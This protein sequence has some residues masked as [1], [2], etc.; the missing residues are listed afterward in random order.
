MK[1]ISFEVVM[2]VVV[3]T[4]IFAYF[5]SVFAKSYYYYDTVQGVLLD[6]SASYPFCDITEGSCSYKNEDSVDVTITTKNVETSIAEDIVNTYVLTGDAEV[7]VSLSSGD[8]I[9]EESLSVDEDAFTV[10]IS[11]ED[12]SG[13]G[14]FTVVISAKVDGI[15]VDQDYFDVIVTEIE[16]VCSSTDPLSGMACED[17]NCDNQDVDVYLIGGADSNSDLAK[18][19]LLCLSQNQTVNMLKANYK[20]T[21]DVDFGA[22]NAID[23]DGN[24]IVD[25]TNTEGWI[26]LGVFTGTF[27][28]RKSNDTAHTISNIYIDRSSNYQGFFGRTDSEFELSYIGIV[29]ADISGNMYAGALIGK[30]GYGLV[31]NC[32]STGK[33]DSDS[34]AAGGLI[35]N[36]A[37]TINDSY[38][39][40]NVTGAGIAHGGLV[41]YDF[42]NT[43]NRSYATGDVAGGDHTGGLIGITMTSATINNCYAT[44]DV[45]AGD[46]AGGLI[47]QAKP[48]TIVNCYATGDVN[49]NDRV[50]GLLGAFY[51]GNNDDSSVD[52]SYARGTVTASNYYG[53]FSGGKSSSSSSSVGILDI[54]NNGDNGTVC[55]SHDTAPYYMA[56][57]TYDSIVRNN[58][59]LCGDADSMIINANWD[60]NVWNGVG[61]TATPTLK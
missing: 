33:V 43:I 19:Q 17:G 42:N 21:A 52:N 4:F 14:E 44:G 9:N 48:A 29:N 1:K 61:T 34:M 20:L 12:I 53:G 32:Y 35:G 41:G 55:A 58:S 54:N 60:P 26:P 51:D 27:T 6:T 24:G 36:A 11:A 38:S 39:D 23:W 18:D 3:V 37:C 40:V 49:G 57:P 50:G 16:F 46:Y 2:I 13:A 30:A 47:G 25:G 7:S 5:G 59:T 31:S 15:V 28:G 10:N 22:Y 45:D 8:I 56:Y